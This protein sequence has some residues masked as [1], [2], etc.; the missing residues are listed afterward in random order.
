MRRSFILSWLTAVIVSTLSAAPENGPVLFQRNCAVCHKPTGENRTPTPEALM[1]LPRKAILDAL[2]TGAMKQQGSA[3]NDAERLAVVDYLAKP[4]TSDTITAANACSDSKVTLTALKG[5]NG[6]GVDFANSRFQ[7][8]S[9]AGLSADD[10][11]KLK[12]KWAF[13]IPNTGV[14]YGQPTVVDGALFFGSADGTVYALDGR[15]GCVHWTFKAPATVRSAISI[16]SFSGKRMAAYFGDVKA[17]VYAIDAASGELLW[18]TQIDEHPAARVTGALKI[19]QGRL[20]VPVSSIEEVS[21]GNPNYVCCKFRGSIVALEA[22][23]GKQIWKTYSIQETPSPNGKSP[24]GVDRFGPSGGAIWSSPSIDEKRKLLYVGS[25]NQYSDPPSKYSDAILAMD[26]ETGALSWSRQLTGSDGWNFACVTLM[27]QGSCPE[28]SG[29]DV[30]IGASP[31][32]KRYLLVSQKSGV[33]SALDPDKQG[34]IVWQARLGKG[35]ALGGV[36][37]GADAD[38]NTMYVPLSDW[39]TAKLPDGSLPGGGL[40]ALQ[41]AT[42]EKVWHTPAPK[43]E[44]PAVRGCSPSQMAPATL[45]PG[46]AFS[47]SMDGHLRAYASSDGKIIWDFDTLHDFETVNGVKAKGGSPNAAG[48]TVSDGMLFVNSGYGALG[49]MAGNVLLAFGK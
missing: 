5:W 12:L 42:G 22:A 30:D 14:M 48:P 10:I 29:P 26:L 17:N 3:L 24:A 6:W 2:T 36:M 31:I 4:S 49:G 13:G 40:F 21:A 23:S 39:S 1:R 43:P 20:Y 33:V 28:N 47:G 19:Y 7:S 9:A 37:W 27:A 45:I 18:E 44:C 41:I 8:S 35:G 32:L 11:P 16:G 25:G 38:D 34:E 15:S 46:V